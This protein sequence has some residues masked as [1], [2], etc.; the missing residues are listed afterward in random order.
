M[1][2]LSNGNVNRSFNPYDLLLIAGEPCSFNVHHI[3]YD[4]DSDNDKTN[5]AILEHRARLDGHSAGF[6]LKLDTTPK[7]G[8]FAFCRLARMLRNTFSSEDKELWKHLTALRLL[9]SEEEDNDTAQ[10]L[11]RQNFETK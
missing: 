1:T 9:K 10:P 5:P 11:C 6:K 3:F 4:N 2:T 7:D 8:D